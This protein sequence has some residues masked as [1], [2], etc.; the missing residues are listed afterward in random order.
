M[1]IKTYNGFKQ[2]VAGGL[3]I[4]GQPYGVM[5]TIGY[6]PNV[7]SDDV[8][9][10]IISYEV[11]NVGTNYYRKDL[12]NTLMTRDDINNRMVLSGDNLRWDLASFSADGAVIYINTGN[13]FTS[14]L[15]AYYGF[16]S[17][18]TS[19]RTAFEL[20]WNSIQGI[21]YLE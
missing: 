16:N 14:K 15:V 3:N 13:D 6:T 1:S 19:R 8:V 11:N 5:L 9:N 17:I 10:D 18:K 12:L 20:I 4:V 21:L 7:V 2:L